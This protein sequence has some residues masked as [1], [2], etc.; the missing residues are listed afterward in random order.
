MSV[1][2]ASAP[3]AENSGV[4]HLQLK[5][6]DVPPYVLLPGAPERTAVMAR[7]WEDAAQVASY[8]EYTTVVGRYKQMPI[9]AVST[10]IGAAGSEIAIH[11]LNTLGVHTCIRVGSTGSIVPEFD[12]GDLIIV[13]AAMRKDGTS[14]TYIDPAYPAVA[15]FR[16]VRALQQ[17]CENLGFRYGFGIA[18]TVSSFY[19]GQGRPIQEDGSGYWPSHA[20]RLLADLR[21]TGVTNIEMEAAGQFVV[22][23]LHGMRMGAIMSVMANRVTDCWGDNGGEAKACLAASEALRILYE[24][25]QKPG[26][27]LCIRR[28]FHFPK[29]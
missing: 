26:G 17:A 3:Q 6:G 18:Y 28:G 16:V 20:D 24:E 12:L 11:E 15:D 29:E 25:D 10:G 14:D 13:T 2:K 7:D 22:G 21:G 19:I 4:Y 5:Q 1:N 9:A 27:E 8:R 23:N